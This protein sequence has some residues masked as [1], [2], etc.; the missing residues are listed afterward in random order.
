MVHPSS[1]GGAAA[2]TA[3]YVGP[4][5][6]ADYG[7]DFNPSNNHLAVAQS[8][9]SGWFGNSTGWSIELWFKHNS[10]STSTN[11]AIMNQ[12]GNIVLISTGG[13]NGV[14]FAGYKDASTG[15]QITSSATISDTDWQSHTRRL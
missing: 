1:G 10:S 3:S 13:G 14:Q 12:H 8:D 15:Y 9:A 7:L 6:A 4:L 2:S 11:D 5:L